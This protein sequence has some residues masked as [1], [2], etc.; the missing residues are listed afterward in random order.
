MFSI[1]TTVNTLV[2]AVTIWHSHSYDWK[3]ESL[4]LTNHGA[5]ITCLTPQ[6]PTRYHQQNLYL[7]QR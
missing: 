1:M 5:N 7:R 6:H 2:S 3:A 4:R